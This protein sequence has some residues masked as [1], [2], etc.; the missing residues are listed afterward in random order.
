[1]FTFMIFGTNLYGKPLNCPS[2]TTFRT[3]FVFDTT[4]NFCCCYIYVLF[5]P[6]IFLIIRWGCSNHVMYTKSLE[7]LFQLHLFYIFILFWT[8]SYSKHLCILWSHIH[9]IITSA[10]PSI[11]YPPSL[12]VPPIS[13]I[14]TMVSPILLLLSETVTLWDLWLP[15]LPLFY[16]VSQCMFHFYGY[17]NVLVCLINTV[18]PTLSNLIYGGTFLLSLW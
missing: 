16:S 13:T 8:H 10:H 5:T 17:V 11:C 2:R 18:I 9:L 14:S 1:M 15:T 4:F 3:I 12:M 7:I 6:S